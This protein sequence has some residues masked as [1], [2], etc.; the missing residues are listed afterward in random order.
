MQAL[1]ELPESFGHP[2]VHSRL[3]IRKL[4]GGLFECRVTLNLRFV[5]MDRPTDLYI[6]FAGNHDEVRAFLKRSGLH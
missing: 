4:R 1:C 3:G 6:W 5:F 2:H